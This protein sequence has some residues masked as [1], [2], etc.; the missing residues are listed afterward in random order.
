MAKRKTSGRPKTAPV[1][2]TANTGSPSLL[3]RGSPALAAI[4]VAWLIVA[5][6]DIAFAL[7]I[8]ETSLRNGELPLASRAALVAYE[9]VAL[10]AVVGLAGGLVIALSRFRRADAGAAVRAGV[11]AAV[12][13]VVWLPV[14]FYGVSWAAFWNAGVFLDREG[15]AFWLPHPVQV[16]HWV[17]PPLA[18]GVL[19]AT[20]VAAAG[21]GWA[22]PNL[23]ARLSNA[24]QT[25][26]VLGAASLAAACILLAV[27]GSAIYDRSPAGL[28]NV[29]SPYALERDR[30]AGPGLHALADLRQWI[31]TPAAA[32]V[33]ASGARSGEGRPIITMQ[34]YLSSVDSARARPLNV[35]M[36]QIESLRADQLRAYGS[37]RDVMPTVDAL[38]RE[39]RVFTNAY[40]QASHSNYADVVPL[41]SHY[42]LRARA[43]HEYP[44]NPTYPRVLIYDVLKAVGYKTAIVS[45]QNER[46]GGMINYHRPENLDHFFHAEVYSGPTISPFEDAGFAEWVQETRGA[47]SV[48]DRYTVDEAIRWVETTMGTP[49]FLH[50][51]LQS[52]HVPYVVPDDFARPFGPKELDFTIMWGRFPRD[53]VDIVKARY[54]DSL[55]Y[56]D[57]QIRRLFD[58]LRRR[59]LWENTIIVIGGDNGEAF[60]EH[61]LA[62]HAST[63]FEEVVKVPMIVRSPEL[64]PGRDDR[65][66]MF[67]DVPPSL[68]D[69][70]GLPRHPSFQGISLF[71]PNPDPARPIFTMVQTPLANQTAVVRSGFKLIDSEGDGLYLYDLKGQGEFEN[72]AASRLDLVAELSAILRDWRERQ[73]AYYADVARHRREYPP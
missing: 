11:S 9:L 5:A 44:V 19:I 39:G 48:D 29:R 62:A 33:L 7:S 56:E 43:M 10:L 54:A 8:A 46:W 18:I 42:P 60:Y 61:G 51:N 3:D 68:F 50:M 40:V 27:V 30:R 12:G 69:L 53:K 20:S 71:Q 66:A 22:A 37:T 63:V 57:T 15:L 16:F 55:H 65:P 41:S 72:I 14:F 32:P 24:A 58:H 6:T 2:T 23:S 38:A 52:S 59:G 13:L 17:Y 25:R 31:S 36:V 64:A 35:V 70:L 49:F 73:L 28:V 21:L 1:P 26:L 34:Q 4:A 47:G 67:L 45:S